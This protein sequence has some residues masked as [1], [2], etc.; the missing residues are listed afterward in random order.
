LFFDEFF[1]QKIVL[2]GPLK[3][4][5]NFARIMGETAGGESND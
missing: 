3:K 2:G 4:W 1:P 5:P